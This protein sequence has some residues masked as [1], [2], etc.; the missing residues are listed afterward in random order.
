MNMATGL[1]LNPPVGSWRRRMSPALGIT[2][3]PVVLP[4]AVE[5]GSLGLHSLH[6]T[7]LDGTGH[8]GERR[9]LTVQWY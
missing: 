4:W 9:E 7:L 6:R 1:S 5:T 8:S 3:L 2:L